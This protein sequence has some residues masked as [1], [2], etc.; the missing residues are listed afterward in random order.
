ME[1][2]GLKLSKDMIYSVSVVLMFFVLEG[3]FPFFKGLQNRFRHSVSNF[4][5][6]I[7]NGVM[8]NVFFSGLLIQMVQ[9]AR[10]NSCGLLFNLDVP[11]YVKD[12]IAFVL[13]DMWMYFWHRINHENKFLWRFHRMHHSD[14]K[15][16]A[17][18]ALRFHPLEII[19]SSLLR[20]AVIPL[21]GMDIV[22]LVIY[23]LIMS[24]I[25]LFHHSNV[26]LSEKI[27]R[28]LRSIIVTPNMH[29]VHHSQIWAETNSNYASV[30]SFWDRIF[31]SFKKRDDP[32]NIKFGLRV[33]QETGWQS[34]KGM[35]LTPLYGKIKGRIL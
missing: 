3:V 23:K 22:F 17:S 33:L 24:P 5:F 1:E 32:H 13:F 16:D 34:I 19:I 31:R 7:G 28:V 20:L 12:I 15:M 26:A 29:R 11:W 6:G 21:L 35:L 2:G 18:T 30:F 27:D 14:L 10:K 4:V 8:D 25:I 9:A